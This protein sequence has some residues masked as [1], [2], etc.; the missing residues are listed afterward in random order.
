MAALDRSPWGVWLKV[1]RIFVKYR[2]HLE[3]WP[4]LDVTLDRNTHERRLVDE[5]VPVDSRRSQRSKATARWNSGQICE[6]E[7]SIPCF[8]RS[9]DEPR[10]ARADNTH[11]ADHI[12]FSTISSR[13]S[14]RISAQLG[15][16]VVVTQGCIS[17]L[18]RTRR[19]EIF[20]LLLSGTHSISRYQPCRWAQSIEPGAWSC[21]YLLESPL[22]RILCHGSPHHFS[23]TP[24]TN[25]Y[26]G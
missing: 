26:N 12:T 23:T 11:G 9:T 7:I 14:T 16:I 13:T 3:L 18:L 25:G 15:T 21:F 8:E 20:T 24:P 19:S 2:S 17:S 1:R 4:S 6:S 10:L 22:A 5:K